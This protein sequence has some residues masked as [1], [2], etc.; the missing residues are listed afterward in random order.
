MIYIT[1]AF[2]F[3]SL[4]SFVFSDSEQAS[5]FGTYE[6]VAVGSVACSDGQNGLNTRLGASLSATLQSVGQINSNANSVS[7][8]N[9]LYATAWSNAAWNSPNC[10]HCLTVTG[11]GKSV[12]VTVVDAK[13][14]SGVDL[15][16]VAW[17]CLYGVGS[18]TNGGVFSVSVYDN[19]YGA[20]LHGGGCSSG[21]TAP[22]PPSP[23]APAPTPKAPAPTPKAPAPT[24][25]A[26][27][28]A[29]PACKSTNGVACA[30]CG[31]VKSGEGCYQ[32][33]TDAGGTAACP[34]ANFNSANPCASTLQIGQSLCVPK[35][36]S[37][38]TASDYVSANAAWFYPVVVVA[39][40]LLI[41]IF[42]VLFTQNKRN[43]NQSVVNTEMAGAAE[44]GEAP[45][46]PVERE[47]YEDTRAKLQETLQ[48]IPVTATSTTEGTAGVET[49][50]EVETPSA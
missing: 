34:W 8:L 39:I 4:N 20:C 18:H 37:A 1:L 17:D 44:L 11:N 41:I 26:P 43:R 49:T 31:T 29:P 16:S 40:L 12:N 36:T 32:V 50:Y 2:L 27:T 15:S 3:L 46:E 22:A 14:A 38:E 5:W 42:Y 45:A 9:G 21:G 25:K 48:Q 7:G 33:W 47:Q 35:M 10:M 13:G 28:P 19:G 6:T 23:P 24:P 30:K